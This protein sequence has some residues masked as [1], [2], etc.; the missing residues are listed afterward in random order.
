MEQENIYQLQKV[1]KDYIHGTKPLNILKDLN[2]E[3]KKGQ[4]LCIIGPSGIGKSTLLHLMGALDQVTSGKIFYRNK[5]LS[6]CTKE[7]QAF[8][9]RERLG[10]VFQFHHLLPEFTALENVR[11]P[12]YLA[13]VSRKESLERA[14]FLLDALDLTSRKSHYPSELSGGEQQRVAI[15]RALMNNPEVLLADEPVGNLDQENAQ[16]IRDLFFKLYEKFKLTLISVSHDRAFAEAFPT[17][18]KMERGMLREIKN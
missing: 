14:E 13:K 18:L 9:R 5:E 11:I 15:A 10:F 4:A 16:K 1:C 8:L 12:A 2:L 6:H 7:Q 3:I 17:V